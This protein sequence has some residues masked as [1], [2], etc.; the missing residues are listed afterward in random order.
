MGAPAPRPSDAAARRTA[1]W[2][3]LLLAGAIVGGVVGVAVL[4]DGSAGGNR[5]DTQGQV[6]EDG[7]AKPH[8][9]ERPNS[10]RAPKHPGDRGGW[11][12]LALLALMTAAVVAIVVVA[13][14]GGGAR[15]RAGRAA[16]R[17]AAES[18]RDGGGSAAPGGEP[19]SST[20]RR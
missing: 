4:T 1:F 20:I 11:E 13:V 14:R 10:G 12:Q 5:R 3:A 15:A 19:P 9:I 7:G 16:W 17:A 18:G 8:I 2:A 6:A